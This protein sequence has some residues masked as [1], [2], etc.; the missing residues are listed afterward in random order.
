MIQLYNS[1]TGK[2][3]PFKPLEEGKVKMYVCG[4]TVYNYI[5][6][7]NA[8]PAIVFDTVRRYF[9][10]RGYDVKYVSNFTDVDDKIIRTAN[11][12]G[13]DYHALTKRFIDAYHADTGALNVQKA[14]IHPLV[15]ETMDDI[16]AFIEVLVEKGNAY[17]SSGDVY[18][19]T[20]SFKDYGQL[21]QQSIDELRSGARIEV[22]EKKEDPLD[23]VLWKA[24]KPGEPAW[25]SPWGKGRPGWHIEC[26][27]MAKKYL[28]DTIDIHAGG[29]DLKFPHHENEIA[30]SEACNSQKFANYW[31]H[32]GFLNIENEKMSKSLGNFLTVHEAIQAV[33]PMVLRFF[34]LSVQ[35]RHPINY[36]RELID[37]AANGLARIRESVANVEHRLAMTANL[38]TANEKWLKRIEEI[39]QHF[40]TSMDDDFNTANAVTDLF[41]LSKEAN[42]Y[43]GEDQV[44]TE[45]LEQFLAVFQELS[46]VL[47]VTL[48]V[49]KG[50][51]DEEVEQLI[52]DRDTARKERD[53]A[54]ADAIRDQLRDQGI[55]LEDT[56]Q[57]MRW[58]RG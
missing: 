46:T 13:E 22:G 30:Q 44:A 16:I 50:L 4:P 27:A 6:I 49:D 21:S 14:D 54:R 38:G 32:N 31:M 55:L 12:L 36:S 8:R 37:Q 10:Y 1:M 9:T 57:G 42:L 43:L 3:E 56:A 17:A 47:G 2:K 5:H 52:R 23:F 34:M 45:V 19:R 28:G 20:R 51:L 25:T 33:D 48:T 39:K 11:E 58:K 24:A 26:S 41:D 40:I 35:Y 53:F 15:T 29:Q 7:G 18:F